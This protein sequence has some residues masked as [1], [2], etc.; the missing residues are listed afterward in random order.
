VT[1]ANPVL[2]LAAEGSGIERPLFSPTAQRLSKRT[3][4]RIYKKACWLES[5]AD[6]GLRLLHPD[7]F[8]A[9]EC[10]EPDTGIPVSGFI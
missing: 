3:G 6:F 10:K 4:D 9:Q 8:L 5:F 2:L 1:G 7:M